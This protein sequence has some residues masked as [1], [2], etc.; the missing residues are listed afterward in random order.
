MDKTKI[1]IVEDEAIIAT[2]IESQL[3]S[4]GYIQSCNNTQIIQTPICRNLK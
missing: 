3:R 4:L 1:L 2:D